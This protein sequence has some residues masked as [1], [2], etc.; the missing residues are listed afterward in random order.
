[1]WPAGSEKAREILFVFLFAVNLLIGLLGNADF[2]DKPTTLKEV[3]GGNIVLVYGAFIT[4]II[5]S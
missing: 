4:V 5:K 3:A 1:M 2:S